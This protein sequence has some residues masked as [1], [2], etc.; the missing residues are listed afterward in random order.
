MR[1]NSLVSASVLS[2]GVIPTTSGIAEMK[3]CTEVLKLL[4]AADFSSHPT[5]PCRPSVIFKSQA[6]RESNK[7]VN[8]SNHASNN[9]V[10]NTITQQ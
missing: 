5:F 9:S 3:A 2:E 7:S 8:R 1:V 4:L 10:N 6:Q